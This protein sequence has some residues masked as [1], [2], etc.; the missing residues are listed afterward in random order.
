MAIQNQLVTHL[1]T[2]Q[3]EWPLTSALGFTIAWTWGRR[4]CAATTTTGW[5]LRGSEPT[6]PIVSHRQWV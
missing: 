2:F 3:R 6:A 5:I 4:N 1:M